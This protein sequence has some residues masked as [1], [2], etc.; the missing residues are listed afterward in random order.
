MDSRRIAALVEPFL[1]IAATQDGG[2]DP[3]Q[4]ALRPKPAVA[5]T[6]EQ[7]EQI[8]AYLD[9]L[10]RWN[11]RMNLSAVRDADGIVTRHF[12][13]S[14]FAARHLFP[15]KEDRR[16]ESRVIDVGSGAG[17][18]GLAIKIWSSGVALTLIESNQ[19]K[20][21]FLREAIRRLDWNDAAVFP[22][23][24]EN[25]PGQAEVVTLRAVERFESAL[26]IATRLLAPA[27]RLALLIGSAQVRRAQELGRDLSWQPALRIPLSASRVLLMGQKSTLS[28]ACPPIDS[29]TLP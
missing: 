29:R 22:G 10:L 26:G 2:E 4:A 1:A 20:A 15:A 18:P 11:A 21:T 23:R 5:L 3:S 7:L 13:E 28:P 6:N 17:F 19:R 14:L 24:A 16:S 8:S 27:G 25:F 12:G 9:L